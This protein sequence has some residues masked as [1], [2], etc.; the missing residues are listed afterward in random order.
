MLDDV[1]VGAVVVGAGVGIRLSCE[2]EVGTGVD[3]AGDELGDGAGVR[4]PEARTG[5]GAAHKGNDG[6]GGMR[7]RKEDAGSGIYQT[8][9][10]EWL[11][12]ASTF[13]CTIRRP[14]TGLLKQRH[15]G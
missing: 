15:T 4:N 7:V 3:A 11:K 9:H 13:F 14:N 5:N 6:G 10:F 1:G 12:T 8:L 2:D